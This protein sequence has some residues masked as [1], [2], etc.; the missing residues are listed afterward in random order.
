[1]LCQ[2]NNIYTSLHKYLKWKKKKS[3]NKLLKKKKKKVGTVATVQNLNK[4]LKKKKKTH[5]I[6]VAATVLH[7]EISW[8]HSA[9]AL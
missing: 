5:E 8:M 4:G 6:T 1:M 2:Y 3:T 9:E 7:S